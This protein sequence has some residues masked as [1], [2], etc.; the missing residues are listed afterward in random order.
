[1]AERISAM[2]GEVGFGEL[3]GEGEFEGLGERGKGKGF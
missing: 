1:M 3:G 2:N